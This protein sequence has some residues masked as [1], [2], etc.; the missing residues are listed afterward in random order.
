LARV[1]E[2]A[3]DEV[4]VLTPYFVPGRDGVEFFRDVRA[5]GVR[6]A[7]ITNSLASTNHVAVHSGYV[8]YRKAL[9]E[10][11]V[12]LYE[13]KVDAAEESADTGEPDR[14]TLHTKAVVV[15]RRVLFV[16]SLNLDP[17]S[18][19]INSEMGIFLDTPQAAG[20]FA[21]LVDGDLPRFTY[22]LVLDEA[23]SIAWRYEGGAEVSI[24]T[25]EPDVGF[26]RAFKA[27]F[28]RL[29]PLEDQL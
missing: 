28:Y 11:G 2:T 3:Q 4:I 19:D 13:L 21:E 15:D 20:D 16:G 29:L 22:R 23:G 17:R 9:L 5:R 14:L 10:G 8:P 7:I 25:S 24:R 12:E 27:G 26:W 6:V 18:I 1:I